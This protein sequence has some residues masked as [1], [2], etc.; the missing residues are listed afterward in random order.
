MLDMSP[1]GT[2]NFIHWN[3]QQKQIATAGTKGLF[4]HN[5]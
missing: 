1:L 4:I 3:D 2:V 5:F